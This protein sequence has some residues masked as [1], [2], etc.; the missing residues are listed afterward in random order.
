M[1]Y[2]K[3]LQFSTTFA[4]LFLSAS[5]LAN[6]FDLYIVKTEFRFL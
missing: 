5:I 1:C 3:F 2:A 4:E 6:T